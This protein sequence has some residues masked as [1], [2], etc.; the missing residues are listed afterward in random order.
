MFSRR[1]EKVYLNLYSHIDMSITGKRLASAE[2]IK[3]CAGR[4]RRGTVQ[5]ESN[6]WKVLGIRR[7]IENEFPALYRGRASAAGPA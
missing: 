4:G 5:E 7:R 1:R 2:T 6:L 3:I